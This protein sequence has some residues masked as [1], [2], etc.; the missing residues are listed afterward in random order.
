MSVFGPHFERVFS[1]HHPV[2]FSVLDLIPQREQQMEIDQ[3]I[4][5]VEVDK[6]INKLKS[7][8]VPGLNRIPPEAYKA[9]GKTMQL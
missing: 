1:N 3:P 2:D 9:L 7:G 5:F 4:T 6:A 8:K